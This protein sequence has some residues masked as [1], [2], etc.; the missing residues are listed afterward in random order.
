MS[1]TLRFI[2]LL[3]LMTLAARGHAD[4]ADVIVYGGTAGGVMS[5]VA[6]ARGGASVILLEPGK[7]LG[8]MVSGGLGWGDVNRPEIVGGLTREYFT[9]V[10]REYGKNEMIWHIEP[11]IAEKVYNDMIREAKV[12]VRFNQRLREKDALKL[13]APRI[14]EAIMESGT[15]YRARI[16][17]D[18][19]YE[20]DLMAGAGVDFRVGRESTKDYGERNA[21]IHGGK[22]SGISGIAV[23]Q[24]GPLPLVST[25]ALG[26]PGEADEKVQCYNFRLCLTRQPENRVGIAK[27]ANYN[28]RDYTMLARL[29]A[30]IKKPTLA[31]V[32]TISPLPNGKT[33]INN[34]GPLSTDL[35]NE[36][37]G[38]PNGTYALREQITARHRD[39]TMGL[40]WFLGHDERVPE[41]LRAETLEWGLA[42]DE[43]ADT[44]NFPF[45]LYVREGRRMVGAYVMTEKDCRDENEKPDS[46]AMGSYMMDCHP[47]QRVLMPGNDF[48]N[49]GYMGGNN[50]ILPYEIPYRSL[51]PKREQCENLVVPVCM[52]ASH[53]AWS[54][55]RMEPQ[56]M[57]MGHAAGVA[58]AMTV[59][60]RKAVQEVS[61]ESLRSTLAKQG[62]VMRWKL[63][64]WIDL[65]SLAGV[66]VDDEKAQY[67]GTWQSTN[68]I[69]PLVGNCFHIAS[70]GE[71]VRTARFTPD[72][73]AGSY[74]VRIFYAA[75]SN[76]AS[77]V[78][79]KVHHARGD[80]VIAIDEREP[81]PK[82]GKAIG[83]CEFAA[84]KD[85]YVEFTTDGADG[86]VVVDAVQWLP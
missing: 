52:S 27:P 31:S 67:A 71:Q 21:G 39:Y 35:P 85:G 65:K 34:G 60:D 1:R 75:A 12:D 15:R 37:W 62:Q 25:A 63:P 44:A 32:L 66:V 17:I 33:D 30:T 23:D 83:R 57:L 10:G 73:K 43:F 72:L 58:A 2:S 80:E 49:E 38:Y 16:W 82:D 69:G 78:K 5:A 29:L 41:A 55:I 51:V 18:A 86:A 42:K 4:E 20:G 40:L 53:V 8:G 70:K 56:F 19:S 50:R 76:R 68:V 14:T 45:Q 9:R 11:H 81:M 28:P 46:I 64:G 54:S 61:V 3:L 36:S 79:V 77:H 47:V 59:R 22:P 48:A 26:K 74:E 6:A 7:H 84:G 13:D 24:D